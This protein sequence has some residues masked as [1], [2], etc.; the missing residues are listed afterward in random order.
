[1]LYRYVLRNILARKAS[2][3]LVVAALAIVLGAGVVSLA[4]YHGLRT[5]LAAT[6]S[7]DN[8]VV[9]SKGVLQVG[10]SHIDK[11]ELDKLKTLPEVAQGDGQILV[12]PEVNV[13]FEPS[14]GALEPIRGIEP[15]A[16]K[17]HDQ[18]HIVAGRLPNPG[19]GE[20]IVGQRLAGRYPGLALGGSVSLGTGDA[21]PVVGV[22]EAGRS[23]LEG[24]A[25][26]DRQRVAIQLKRQNTVAAVIRMRNPE[27]AKSLIDQIK[28][29]KQGD[30]WALS[31]R[32]YYEATLGNVALIQQAVAMIIAVL[33]ICATFAAANALHASFVGRFPE[34]AT[35]WVLGHRRRRLVAIL[36]EESLTLAAAAAILACGLA[37]LVSGIQ[38]TEIL[39]GEVEFALPFGTQQ[40]IDAFAMAGVIA[41]LGAAYPVMKILRGDLVS[42]LS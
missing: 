6:G 21:W 12:S 27:A 20:L 7:P 18:V 14:P 9:L 19:A 40:A 24:E 23:A 33:A 31:E 32:E 28:T 2:N 30:L 35:L 16:F 22:F 3:A 1:V 41:I 37:A 15:V 13:D 26:G 10:K 36:L 4:F 17:V 39:G 25:W 34:F 11:E 5:N 29:I 42:A 8:L 38:V